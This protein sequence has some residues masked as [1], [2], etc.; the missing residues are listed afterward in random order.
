MIIRNQPNPKLL[1]VSN[2]LFLVMLM[3]FP[4]VMG[5]GNESRVWGQAQ[6]ENGFDAAGG[7]KVKYE[8]YRP[9]TVEEITQAINEYCKASGVP[10]DRIQ[11]MLD[12]WSKVGPSTPASELLER[13]AESLVVVDGR[14]NDL[15]EASRSPILFEKEQELKETLMASLQEMLRSNTA[16]YLGVQLSGA[17]MYEEA[18]EELNRSSVSFA[19]D[20]AAYFFHKAVC[21]HH[22]LKKKEALASLGNL[23]ERTAGV[24]IRY[25][26]VAELMR[27]DLENLKDN[28]LDEVA[29]MM[30]DVERRL[31]LG[32]AGSNVQKLEREIISRLDEMIEKMEQQQG[33][34][35]GNQGG[36]SNNPG[37]SPL[38]DSIVKGSTAP[39][40]V[41]NKD[42]GH[43]DG[44][45]NLPEKDQAKAK[46]ILGTLYP[47]HYQKAIEEY[48][49]KSAERTTP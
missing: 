13:M 28:S 41:D 36:N 29:R 33:G 18:L 7:A 48:S 40:N 17:K 32:R 21:E 23:L 20:P 22:L 9:L 11:V 39:G 27:Y 25:A 1:I 3:T 4:L 26:Q 35:G 38:E 16:I 42:I 45:G 31:D 10:R 47:S 6:N 19:I 15:F 2:W 24:P 49:R 44:W 30:S 37:S 34:G 14:W 46:Q 43:Q 5:L 12:R 8:V